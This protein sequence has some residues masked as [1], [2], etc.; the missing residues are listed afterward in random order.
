MISWHFITK[1]ELMGIFSTFLLGNITSIK[2][3]PLNNS[4]LDLI[5]VHFKCDTWFMHVIIIIITFIT[6]AMNYFFNSVLA[7]QD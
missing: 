2:R 5:H 7:L 3:K 1:K 6:I 4:R